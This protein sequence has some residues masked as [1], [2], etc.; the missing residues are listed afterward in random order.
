MTG[1]GLA[2]ALLLCRALGGRTLAEAAAA[3]PRYPQFKVNVPTSGKTLS[4]GLRDELADINT[5]LA[6][7]GRV[8][9]RP[10][11]TEPLVRILAEA[12]NRESA[13]DLCARVERLVRQEIG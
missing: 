3:M 4:Q 13:A 7:S 12:E 2:A 8:L 9:V 10:S 1:D 6:G 5:N 11:G